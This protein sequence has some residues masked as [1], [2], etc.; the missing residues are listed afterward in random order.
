MAVGLFL[1]RCFS[2]VGS[3]DKSERDGEEIV[4]EMS[5]KTQGHREGGLKL[6]S[7]TRTSSQLG[8]G[9]TVVGMRKLSVF[10]KTEEKGGGAGR[11]KREKPLVLTL[12]PRCHALLMQAGWMD[13]WMEYCVEDCVELTTRANGL[14]ARGREGKIR[15]WAESVG[16]SG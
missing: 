15:H 5:A 9:K 6:A 16:W 11:L 3:D 14:R 7:H 2:A 13:G 4:D 10:S 12:I 1:F 8:R